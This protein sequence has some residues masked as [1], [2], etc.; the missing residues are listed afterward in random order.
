MHALAKDTTIRCTWSRPGE[1]EKETWLGKTK[2]QRGK[3]PGVQWS[4]HL[5]ENTDDFDESL[6]FAGRWD[7]LRDDDGEPVFEPGELPSSSIVGHVYAVSL[8]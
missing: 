5:V 3:Y 1:D 8:A 6:P 7:H 4:H 2:G